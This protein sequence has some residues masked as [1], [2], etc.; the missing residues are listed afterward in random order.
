MDRISEGALIHVTVDFVGGEPVLRAIVSELSRLGVIAGISNVYK[1]FTT[2]PSLDSRANL[3]L[4]LKII[5]RQS[6]EEISNVVRAL[7]KMPP[8]NLNHFVEINILAY[9]SKVWMSPQLTLPYPNL[10]SDPLVL[11]C[12][13]EV[14]S[15]F[16]HP[17][18]KLALSQLKVPVSDTLS[19]FYLQGGRLLTSVSSAQV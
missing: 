14:D 19:E 9:G 4:V 3:E 10:H 6:V 8:E 1:R 13:C 11:M 7:C 17:I 15:Q 18:L 2:V 5:T 16:I 12:A